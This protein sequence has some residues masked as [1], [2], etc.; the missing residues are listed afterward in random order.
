VYARTVQAPPRVDRAIMLRACISLCG[1]LVAAA[2]SMDV[3]PG[4]AN[5]TW[6][7]L[8]DHLAPRAAAY[9]LPF[10]YDLYTFRGDGGGTTVVA[11][12]AVPAGRLQRED[13][14]RE[15]RYRFDVT[16]VLADTVLRTVFRTDDSVFVSLA[17]PLKREHLLSTHIEVEAPPSRS[18]V[19]RVIMTDATTAG[20]GQLYTSFFP[21]PDYSGRDLMLSDIALSQADSESGW[22]RGGVT[23]GLLPTSEFPGSA[24]DVYYEIYNLPAGNRYTT[25]IAIARVAGADGEPV[26]DGSPVRLRYSGESTARPGGTLPELRHVD[27]SVENGRYRITV[28]ITDEATG[29]TA[30]RARHFQVSGWSPG[31]TLVAALPRGDRHLR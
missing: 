19:Q 5:A 11:A 26:P 31:A 24:F 6:A 14:A 30:S 2:F 3:R 22:K 10:F 9:P 1:V 20:I 25:E 7:S 29:Q 27:A 4:S 18:T 13:F 12:F 21:I 16:L 15:V 17:R 23:L 8:D 28:T